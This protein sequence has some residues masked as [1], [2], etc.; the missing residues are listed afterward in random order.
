MPF[1]VAQERGF[2]REED[3]EVEVIVQAKQVAQKKGNRG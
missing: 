2:F 3:L 1:F